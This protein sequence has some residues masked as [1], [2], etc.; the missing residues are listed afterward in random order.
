MDNTSVFSTT[1]LSAWKERTRLIPAEDF[2]IRNYLV[3]KRRTLEA[4]AGAGRILFQMERMGFRSLHGIDVVYPLVAH[5]RGK[6]R[7]G[8]ISLSIQ[9]AVQLAY[10]NASFD[11]II[12]LQQV[13][14]FIDDP[15][16][17]TVAV[18]EAYRV[19]S[20][21]GTALF[22]FLSFDSRISSAVYVPFLVYL[23]LARTVRGL[24][25]SVQ[26]LPWLR[27]SGK[28]NWGAILDR[29]P[30]VYWFRVNEA[31]EL[32]RK[33]GFNITAVGS[34]R[35]LRQGMIYPSVQSLTVDRIHGMLYFVATKT[36]A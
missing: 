14:C 35:Q 32:L 17:R 29:A 31:A 18:N 25:R 7:N 27:L 6:D 24:R 10:K 36:T 2:L 4:G 8:T 12:Y 22:S 33:A 11:Q 16:L 20:P 30:Y 15:A 28:F 34:T 3:A 23:R 19:L 13:L 1:E 9:N 5:A 26:I 21:G